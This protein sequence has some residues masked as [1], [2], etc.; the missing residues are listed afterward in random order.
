V[1]IIGFFVV[2]LIPVVWTR[3]ADPHPARHLSMS[4]SAADTALI[5]AGRSPRAIDRAA[6]QV[7]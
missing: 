5:F 6:P 1:S 2:R 7:P 4:L 3:D